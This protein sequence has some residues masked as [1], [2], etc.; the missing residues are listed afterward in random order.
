[1]KE[2][3]TFRKHEEEAVYAFLRSRQ[4]LDDQVRDTEAARNRMLRA[5]EASPERAFKQLLE[6]DELDAAR[7]LAHHEAFT[8]EEDNIWSDRRGV[9]GCIIA[10]QAD[11]RADDPPDP[12]F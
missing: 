8:E 5:L 7:A 11:T 3:R 9:L 10:A 12:S 6:A 4:A 2:A 1:M